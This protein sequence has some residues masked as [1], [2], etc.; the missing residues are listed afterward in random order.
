MS[1]PVV[2]LIVK[3][4]ERHQRLFA[5]ACAE[6]MLPVWEAKRHDG[7]RLR[8]ALQVAVDYA[9]GKATNDDLGKARTRVK[10]MYMAFRR[11]R[12]EAAVAM[13]VCFTLSRYR[14]DTMWPDE[15]W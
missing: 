9:N 15:G 4:D 1:D 10:D 7:Q 13:I 12:P 2:E 6:R 3:L 8:D 14:G 5:C 11:S